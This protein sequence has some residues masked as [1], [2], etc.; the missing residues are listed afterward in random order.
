M[1]KRF[2]IASVCASFLVK[3]LSNIFE[4]LGQMLYGI[5]RLVGFPQPTHL[6]F[7]DCFVFLVI[8]PP[9]LCPLARRGRAGVDTYCTDSKYFHATIHLDNKE[10]ARHSAYI[11]FVFW[12]SLHRLFLFI[13][14]L[15]A[16]PFLY[17]FIIIITFS[18]TSV[19]FYSFFH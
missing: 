1:P 4:Q 2:L 6:N 7:L 14:T 15:I 17:D 10:W 8:L 16:W 19:I 18:F 12:F 5:P 11:V 3:K 13:N 9:S